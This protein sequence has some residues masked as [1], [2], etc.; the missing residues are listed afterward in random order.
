MTGL[1]ACHV[2][3]PAEKFNRNFEELQQP[4]FDETKFHFVVRNEGYRLYSRN[5]TNGFRMNEIFDSKVRVTKLKYG[6]L[7]FVCGQII[8]PHW[9]EIKEKQSI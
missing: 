7:L 5:A 3:A 4:D 1:Q 2:T 6:N 9:T 8:V